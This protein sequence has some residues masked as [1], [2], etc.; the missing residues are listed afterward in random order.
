[1]KEFLKST[2]LFN[3]LSN[4]ELEAVAKLIR[5][6]KYG[7][8]QIVFRENDLGRTIF[9]V[10]SGKFRLSVGG[11]N[12]CEFTT[13]DVFG[14]LALINENLRSGEVVTIEEGILFELNGKDLINPDKL[15][16]ATS[17]AIIRELARRVTTYL[18]PQRF[19]Q[20]R[21]LI[22][23]GENDQIEFKSSLRFNYFTKKFGKEIEHA[24]IKSIAAFLNS[25]GG[26]LLIGIDDGGEVL[27]IAEDAF[28]NNDKTLL[29]LTKLISGKI[30]NNH[31]AFIKAGVEEINGKK[32]IRV[33]IQP[34]TI[35]AYV[36][37][38]NEE[39][40]YVRTGPSTN[41]LKASV[42]FLYVY[43]RFFSE[44]ARKNI[45]S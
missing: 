29:H 14:E 26:T 35:P 39:F 8:G 24:V 27:G 19:V 43:N 36:T 20:T 7:S 32:V 21:D 1:M 13:G 17:L 15:T 42:I 4:E 44:L 40:L 16:P 25:A 22:R 33:D 11:Q 30:G 37:N 18:R 28:E 6:R 45:Q 2:S 34:S 5:E 41:S 12:I 3:G 31:L 23:M 10:F 38:N 9:I